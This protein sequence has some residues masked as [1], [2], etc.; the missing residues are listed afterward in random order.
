MAK[1]HEITLLDVKSGTGSL[2]ELKVLFHGKREEYDEFVKELHDFK[3]RMNDRR[4]TR[5][6][7]Q[8]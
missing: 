5:L 3:T 2:H 1:E 6:S 8:E 7:V 4:V